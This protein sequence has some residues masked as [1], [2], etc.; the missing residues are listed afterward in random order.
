MQPRIEV[1]VE[2]GKVGV[3]GVALLLVQEMIFLVDPG[4]SHEEGKKE[5]SVVGECCLDETVQPGEKKELTEMSVMIEKNLPLSSFPHCDF[6]D[7]GYFIHA[8]AK[9]ITHHI[10]RSLS[11]GFC[12][13][14]FLQNGRLVF[15]L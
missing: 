13:L 14:I 1:T 6:I 3:E 5:I 15:T 11:S 10:S 2:A 4:T 7:V 9:V 8:V 12:V